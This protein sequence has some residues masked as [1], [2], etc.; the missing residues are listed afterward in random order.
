M[1]VVRCAACGRALTAPVER[2]DPSVITYDAIERA[3][4]VPRGSV[5]RDPEAAMMSSHGRPV[6][7][8]PAGAIVVHPDD[9]VTDA[10]V[11]W[12]VDVG[13]CGSD[14]CDGPNRACTCGQVVGTAMT[15]CW[16]A[17]EMRFH[18]DAVVES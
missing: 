6:E 3:P 10:L 8:S 18:P 13:C 17:A 2:A 1:T 12:G 15:D 4:T 5:A 9:L 14:G 7:R 16:T 11:S